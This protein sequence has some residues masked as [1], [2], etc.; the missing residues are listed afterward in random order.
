V[1]KFESHDKRLIVDWLLDRNQIQRDV[2]KTRG[3]KLVVTETDISG[4]LN[5]LLRLLRSGEPID[6]EIRRA[7][8]AALDPAG[9]SVLQ[10]KK[11]LRRKRGRPAKADTVRGAA[12]DAAKAV[13]HGRR[14][15]EA[16]AAIRKSKPIA[17][18]GTTQKAPTEAE[19]IE[20]M[21]ISHTENMRRSKSNRLIMN[22]K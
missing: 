3:G 20:R 14:V 7:L 13:F 6:P 2:R 21:D 17:A 4:G 15:E 9:I 12:K 8:A 16:R 1:E 11:R 19:I 10:L 5:A 22:K 18:K